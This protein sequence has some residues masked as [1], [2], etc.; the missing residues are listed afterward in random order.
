M[1][2]FNMVT[3]T[4][5]SCTVLLQDKLV[6]YFACWLA[7][8]GLLSLT[9]LMCLTEDLVSRTS[10]VRLVRSLHDFFDDSPLGRDGSCSQRD[11]LWSL[12]LWAQPEAFMCFTYSIL[13]WTHPTWGFGVIYWIQHMNDYSKWNI[14]KNSTNLHVLPWYVSLNGL[15]L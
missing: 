13:T 9:D 5:H 11:S 7:A 4:F 14:I 1:G 10:S 2:C 8:S 3:K 6:S 12:F 15:T